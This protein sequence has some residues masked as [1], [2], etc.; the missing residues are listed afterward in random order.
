MSRINL[1]ATDLDAFLQVAEAGSFRGAAEKMRLSQPAVSARIRHLEDGLGLRL[2]DR[3]TRRVTLT[4]AGVR[5]RQR[6]E[7]MFGELRVLVHELDDEAHLR[8]GR[9]TIGATLS[10]ATSFLP[11]AIARF[12]QQWPAIEVILHDNLYGRDLERLSRGELD[13]A[14]T[15]FVNGDQSFCFEPLLTDQYLV[16]VPSRHPLASQ[17]VVPLAALGT[18]PLITMPPQSAAWSNFQEAFASIGVEF[19]PAFQT[20]SALTTLAMVREGVGIGFV[21]RL[22]ATSVRMTDITLLP[23]E[24]AV[25]SR[26][27]GIVTVR[28]RA[29]LPSGLAFAQVIRQTCVE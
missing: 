12:R 14:V 6:V 23:L 22:M 21:T 2:F 4:S 18:E 20:R 26:E 1:S 16:A 8:R 3:T 27:V 7:L 13:L 11:K 10:V 5:L 25:L 9:V 29:L 17:E 28:G 24:D 15:P 19:R